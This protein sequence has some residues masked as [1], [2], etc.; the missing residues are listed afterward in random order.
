MVP[1]DTFRKGKESDGKLQRFTSL[2]K[3]QMNLL[4]PL[5]FASIFSIFWIIRCI[6]L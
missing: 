6:L 1:G 3:P 4:L 2:M 5:F